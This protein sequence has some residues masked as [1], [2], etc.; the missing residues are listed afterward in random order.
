MLGSSCIAKIDIIAAEGAERYT[1]TEML[2]Y[3]AKKW[4]DFPL[5]EKLK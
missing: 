5:D 4:T 3:L 1:L 2:E